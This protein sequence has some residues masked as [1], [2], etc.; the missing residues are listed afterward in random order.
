[1]DFSTNKGMSK[2]TYEDGL[3]NS[4]SFWIWNSKTAESYD[5][6]EYIAF[7]P[8]GEVGK[9]AWMNFDSKN[10]SETGSSDEYIDGYEEVNEVVTELE[11]TFNGTDVYTDITDAAGAQALIEATVAEANSA[12][13]C[14]VSEGTQTK[15]GYSFDVTLTC[16]DDYRACT[17]QTIT[18]IVKNKLSPI[19]WRFNNEEAIADWNKGRQYNS[20]NTSVLKDGVMYTAV[21]ATA[22]VADHYLGATAVGGAVQEK[23]RFNREDYPYLKIKYRQGGFMSRGTVYFDNGDTYIALPSTP[24]ANAWTTA[25]YDLAN[26]TLNGSVKSYGTGP[27]KALGIWFWNNKTAG[28]SYDEIEYV[29]FFPAGA[30]GKAEWEAF[31]SANPTVAGSSDAYIEGYE[32]IAAVIEALDTYYGEDAYPTVGTVEEARAMIE[33]TIIEAL[34]TSGVKYVL[35][36]GSEASNGYDFDLTLTYGENYMACQHKELTVTLMTSGGKQPLIWRFNTAEAVADWQTGKSFN[37]DAEGNVVNGTIV[38]NVLKTPIAFVSGTTGLVSDHYLGT[39]G[40]GAVMPDTLNFNREDYP[41]FKVKYRHNGFMTNGQIYIGSSSNR[42]EFSVPAAN[43]WSTLAVDF[44][45]AT[46]KAG[47]FGTGPINMFAFWLWNGDSSLTG[48]DEIEYIAFF[49]KGNAG[50]LA[51]EAFDSETPHLTASSDAYLDGYDMVEPIITALDEIAKNVDTTITDADKAKALVSDAVAEAAGENPV[52]YTIGDAV[53]NDEGYTVTVTLTAGTNLKARVVRTT[54]VVIKNEYPDPIIWKFNNPEFVSKWVGTGNC[55]TS[56]VHDTD[57]IYL[58]A[59]M[60][61]PK[62]NCN[63]TWSNIPEENRFDA[64]DYPYIAIRYKSSRAGNIQ[65]YPATSIS[66]NTGASGSFYYQLAMPAHT[67]DWQTKVW[68]IKTDCTMKNNS[69]G[70]WDGEVKYLRVDFMR[71]AA[72]LKWI[73]VDY[74]AF[75]A[76]KEQADEFVAAPYVYG[77]QTTVD[78]FADGVDMSSLE[79]INEAVNDEATAKAKVEELI[80]SIELPE[81]VKILQNIAGYSAGDAEAKDGMAGSYTATIYFVNGPLGASAVA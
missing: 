79:V 64:T 57:G 16:G 55:P 25:S 24:A 63:I 10:P 41:Y 36:E 72:E 9:A 29:A 22:T 37:K 62:D 47:S 81:G 65:L 34:G 31:D 74:I 33:A 40:T 46:F 32:G 23:F 70:T 78:E 50:R 3:M 5:E 14:T 30:E 35:S 8:S 45:T 73:N 49:P 38:D 59:A 4:I 61:E 58:R 52:T 2:G 68:N 20:A 44:S 60:T 42:Y 39:S 12:V 51:W 13:E 43:T 53:A 67:G 54:D 6:I 76:T 7:F 15:Y 75:F 56:F 21:G 69:V 77:N 19:I 11:T 48:Y 17:S 71:S 66:T 1:L 28:D 27:M 18:V 26:A 80:A